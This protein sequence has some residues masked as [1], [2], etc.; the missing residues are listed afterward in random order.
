MGGLCLLSQL[1]MEV[2]SV[3]INRQGFMKHLQWGKGQFL[4]SGVGEGKQ[5]YGT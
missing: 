1:S 2:A 3:R 5:M 4:K